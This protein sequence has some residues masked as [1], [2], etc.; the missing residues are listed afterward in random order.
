MNSQGTTCSLFTIYDSC[1]IGT[2]FSYWSM[3]FLYL[4]AHHQ[5]KWEGGKGR[6][7]KEK[8]IGGREERH[9]REITC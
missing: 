4:A 1:D 9:K 5:H 3:L 6:K 2:V 7:E 8:G